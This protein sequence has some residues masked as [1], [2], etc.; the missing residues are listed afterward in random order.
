MMGIITKKASSRIQILA[1]CLVFCAL[2]LM[3]GHSRIVLAQDADI[4]VNIIRS[5]E[6][7]VEA[8][9]AE[10]DVYIDTDVYIGGFD[11]EIY[12][13]EEEIKPDE[14]EE[15]SGDRQRRSQRGEQPGDP[16][17]PEAREM[18]EEEG[19]S[20]EDLM[21]DPELR[22][23]FSKRVEKRIRQKRGEDS[24]PGEGSGERDKKKPE[25]GE[26]DAPAEGLERYTSIIVKK[27]LFLQ[28]GSGD[29]KRGPSYALTA[30]ISDT[31]DRSNDKA[32]I[33]Q[34]GGGSSYYLS[35][36]DTFAGGIELVDIEDDKVKLDNSGE[37]MTL[38][39]GEGAG[40]GDRRGG[41]GRGRGGGG[42]RGAGGGNRPSG[43]GGEGNKGAPP[44]MGGGGNFDASQL[45][46]NIRRVLQERN[47]SMEQLRNNPQ[48]QQELRREFMRSRG[49]GDGAPQRRR[50]E[51]ARRAGG[52]RGR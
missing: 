24:Q 33:E 41:G 45:T 15:A 25:E 10:D 26:K 11:V 37:E 29:E 23:K 19:I 28:L 50:L 52:R 51:G 48:L 2:C 14:D 35:Q 36:G 44:N 22:E 4:N 6:G 32:I 34:Q 13:E 18:M 49:G 5:G 38:N 46:P 27:N 43:G 40:G 3:S 20:E 1:L 7:R 47:I 39:L 9:E 12:V 42:R 17:P 21:N 30:V 31:S 8:V 16:F